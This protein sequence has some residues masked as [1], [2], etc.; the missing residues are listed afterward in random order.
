MRAQSGVRRQLAIAKTLGVEAHGLHALAGD[1][2]DL[3]GLAEVEAWHLYSLLVGSK[4]LP[5][6]HLAH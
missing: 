6:F 1:L 3:R 5:L 4:R 2:G